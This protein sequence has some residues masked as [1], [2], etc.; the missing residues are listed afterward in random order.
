MPTAITPE[1]LTALFRPRNVALVGASNKSNFSLVAYHNLVQYGFG[2][3][4]YLVNKRGAET[5]GQQTYTSCTEIPVPVDLA[6]MMVPQAGTLDALTDAHAAGV[7][8]AVILSSGYAEAGADG[9]KAEAELLAHAESLD[10]ALLGPNMLGFTNFV[11]GVTATSIPVTQRSPGS[12]GL[13]SQ[14]GAS[15]SAMA[16]FAAMIGADLSYMVTLGNEAMITVGHVLDFLVEDESTKAIAIFMETIRDPET[17]RRAALKAAARGKAIV[18]LKAGSSELSAR[19]AA[20]HTGALVGDDKVI[21]ALFREFGVIRVDSIEDMMV[22]AQVAA[23]VGLLDRPGIGVASISG[24]ACDI[25]ADRAQDRGALLPELAPQTR[26]TIEEFFAAYGTIQNPL[27]VTGAAVIDPSIFTKSIV[28][29]SK[30]PSIGVVAVVS[31]I[32]WENDGPSPAEALISSI[33]NGIAQAEVPAVFVNQVLQPNTD[34]TRKIMTDGNVPVVVPGIQAGVVA[35]QNVVT[36]SH[37]VQEITSSASHAPADVAVPDSSARRGKWSES[38]ARGLLADA[39]VPVV[40]ATLVT[41]ADEAVV[42]AAA[43]G[44]AV[45]LKIASPDILHKSD[46]G[47]VR[48]NV[49]GADDVRAAF[50]AVHA[51]AAAVPG[52]R[53]EGVLIS[54]MRPP[55]TE[56][57]VGVV[58][59]PQWGP[60]LAVGLGGIFVEVLSDSVLTPLPV[61]PDRARQLLDQLRGST[62]LDGVRGGAAANRDRLAEVI[63][64]V[65][66]L[67][68]ALGPDLVSLEINPLRVNGSEIE[69]LDAVVEWKDQA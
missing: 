45:V 28:A 6:Y 33:G 4:T 37:R 31:S 15:S 67:A 41:T 64:R 54:P 52:A 51:S 49:S 30:D 11:D 8:N 47:G 32:P 23:H 38:T 10:M 18:I 24:G 65:G 43:A 35:L 57:L 3:R 17:F 19:T 36:W 40:P 1:R 55:A 58:R 25:I 13:L 22:T 39:G 56:L 63:S 14:S 26:S 5:H 29:L 62:V 59:D 66:D 50:D 61:T 12:I 42:A 2:D 21:D 46:I 27:D 48:L 16:D 20:A 60:I 7:R 53:V 34:Y 44:A 69:A 9:R 68:V